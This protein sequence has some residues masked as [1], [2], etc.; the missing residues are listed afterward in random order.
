MWCD[1][2]AETVSALQLLKKKDVE[3]HKKIKI[4]N[5]NYENSV[6]DSVQLENKEIQFHLLPLFD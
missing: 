2:Y 6:K 4:M 3:F 5:T 1:E